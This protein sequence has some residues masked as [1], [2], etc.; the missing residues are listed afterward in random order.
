[1]GQSLLRDICLHQDLFWQYVLA[2]YAVL[3]AWLGS[4]KVVQANS[5][6]A[7]IT[8]AIKALITRRTKDGQTL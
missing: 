4:T 6:L 3:E 1:M 8:N 5:M 2:G 7:L